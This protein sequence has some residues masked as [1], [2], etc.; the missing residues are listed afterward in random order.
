M[1]CRGEGGGELAEDAECW[2][3]QL[4][5]SASVLAAL[6][7]DRRP[8]QR[9]MRKGERSGGGF[10]LG[11]VSGQGRVGLKI[12]FLCP[13]ALYRHANL[14]NQVTRRLTSPG[15]DRASAGR[16]GPV[17]SRPAALRP[18]NRQ[19]SGVSNPRHQAA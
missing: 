14:S 8:C 18:A 19:A 17:F 2:M 12:L 13:S 3:R 10:G 16:S 15:F 9:C 5:R 6:E 4:G 1:G 11:G 7:S